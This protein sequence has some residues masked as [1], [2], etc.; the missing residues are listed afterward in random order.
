MSP[1]SLHLHPRT[2]HY[3]T[4]F[5]FTLCPSPEYLI[6]SYV[7]AQCILDVTIPAVSQQRSERRLSAGSVSAH[8]RIKARHSLPGLQSEERAAVA[9]TPSSVQ[10]IDPTRL[11]RTDLAQIAADATRCL[12]VALGA[13]MLGRLIETG[14]K[15]SL[16]ASCISSFFSVNTPLHARFQSSTCGFLSFPCALSNHSA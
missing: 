16:D 14:R 4:F 15:S 9:A 3:L 2:I 6:A 5:M 1:T 11:I 8:G 10:C 13:R 12:F 7:I